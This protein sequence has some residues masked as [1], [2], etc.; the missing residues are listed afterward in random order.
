MQI[1]RRTLNHYA[2]ALIFMWAVIAGTVA[3]LEVI[4]PDTLVASGSTTPHDLTIH[5]G[6]H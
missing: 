4:W 6:D 5:L 1:N 3:M 2:T